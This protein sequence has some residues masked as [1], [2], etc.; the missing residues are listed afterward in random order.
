M[1]T[2][3]GKKKVS[4]HKKKE[5]FF[6][7]LFKNKVAPLVLALV[8]LVLA[9]LLSFVTTGNAV[10]SSIT[11]K[12]SFLD[13][14]VNWDWLN[15]VDWLQICEHAIGPTGAQSS[16]TGREILIYVIV[17][18]IIFVMLL[19]LL[20]LTSIFSGWVSFVIALGFSIIAAM[21]G[22]IR[23]IATWIITLG[24][25]LGIAAGFLEII[26]SIVIFVGLAFGS[27]RIAIWAAKRRA[28][29]ETIKAIKGAGETGGAITALKMIQ[30]KF[31]H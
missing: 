6:S 22:T 28:Q 23:I 5:K 24:A 21:V 31:K 30:E 11:G 15:S 13:D 4:S 3:R 29:R 20:L 7:F 18:A 2:K 26:I 14:P 1:K 19:D 17:L 16:C 27:S 12:A 25:G 10:N 8:F 9:I